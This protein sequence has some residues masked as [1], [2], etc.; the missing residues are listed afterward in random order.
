MPTRLSS[1]ADNTYLVA[2]CN[3]NDLKSKTTSTIYGN[4]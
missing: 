3:A 2:L 1:K 4:K